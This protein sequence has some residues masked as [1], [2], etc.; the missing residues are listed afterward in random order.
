[1]TIFASAEDSITLQR[2]EGWDRVS[3]F[4]FAAKQAVA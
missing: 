3:G 2:F 1:M 4:C